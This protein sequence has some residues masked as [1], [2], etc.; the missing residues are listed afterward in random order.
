MVVCRNGFFGNRLADIAERCG[1]QT[2]VVDA[3]WGKPV[4]PEEL[5]REL[6][7]HPKVKAV[8]VVHGETSTGVLTPLR[9]IVD[10]VHQH[11]AIVIVDAVTSLGGQDVRMDEWD[12]DVCYSAHPK[13]LGGATGSGA[14]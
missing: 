12:L 14:Y 10:L 2:H 1:A 4:S 13:V 5:A 9:E 8:G 11:D 6:G 3:P 7:K